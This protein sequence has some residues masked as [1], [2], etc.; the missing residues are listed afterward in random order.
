MNVK[1]VK[2]ITS[3]EF[4]A[5]VE[6]ISDGTLNVKNP[7]RLIPMEK[8]VMPLPLSLLVD[9][10]EVINISIAKTIYVAKPAEH[11]ENMYRQTVGGIVIPPKKLIV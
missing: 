2:L 1:V 7:I 4:I 9:E 11:I 3:E 10:N 8:S 5:E 6:S